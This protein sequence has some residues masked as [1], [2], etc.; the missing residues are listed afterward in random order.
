MK[1]SVVWMVLSNNAP[2]FDEL[3]AMYVKL[4]GKKDTKG[5]T[6]CHLAH[7]IDELTILIDN[8]DDFL[9]LA[10]DILWE[11]NISREYTDWLHCEYKVWKFRAIIDADWCQYNVIAFDWKYRTHYLYESV[12]DSFG[13]AMEWLRETSNMLRN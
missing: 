11:E 9:K 10:D 12:E 4:G 3:K 7:L 8:K 13:W 5:L 2:S 1:Q 6:K